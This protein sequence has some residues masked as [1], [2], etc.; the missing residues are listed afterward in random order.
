MQLVKGAG[1]QQFEKVNPLAI[2]EKE[3]I[4][5]LLLYGNLEVDFIDW[6]EVKAENGKIKLEKEIYTNAVSKEM[7]LHLQ[8]DEIEFSN[9]VF[10]SIYYELIHQLNQD[11]KISIDRLINHQNPEVASLVTSVLMDEEKYTLS[12][13]ER[14][15][16]FVTT[17]EKILPKLVN[18]AVFNLRRVL[19]EKKIKDI[20]N[21]I[22]TQRIAPDLELIND[23]T[24]LRAR[25]FEKLN[26]VI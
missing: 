2:L 5:I 4:R 6:I 11:E 16:I 18:D 7:Y 10:K 8:D 17:T 19:I 1:N 25:L 14:K 23:Y 24:G 9:E 15:E 21:E 20:L 3:V 12:D 22:Q 26:R 13:W